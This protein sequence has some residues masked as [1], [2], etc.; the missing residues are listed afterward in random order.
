M[1][2]LSGYDAAHDMNSIKQKIKFKFNILS[3]SD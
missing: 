1:P 3:I 2:D